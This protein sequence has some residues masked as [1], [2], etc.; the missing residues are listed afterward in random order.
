MAAS[1]GFDG[2]LPDLEDQGS[3]TLQREPLPGT[4]VQ[5]HDG[6]SEQWRC[7]T[8]DTTQA[9]RQ[10]S[11]LWVCAE[12]S[13]TRFYPADEPTVRRVSQG[14]WTYVPEK[15]SPFS[16]S[17]V[18][19]AL[20][21]VCGASTPSRSPPSSA[22]STRRRRRRRRHGGFPGPDGDGP[23]G[24]G[25]EQAESETMTYDSV[26]AVSSRRT[27]PPSVTWMLHLHDELLYQHIPEI[28]ETSIREMLNI[29]QCWTPCQ[30]TRRRGRAHPQEEG[31]ELLH[32][33]MDERGAA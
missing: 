6:G 8:C 31:G 33:V 30:T 11:G 22:Q 13:C 1:D 7:W 12:C 9:V 25:R 19:S 26:V 18:S 32:S 2:S 10:P 27:P 4:F 16:G 28:L 20:A 23:D 17:P 14:V 15:H 3:V 5:N 24:E 21:P 29:R